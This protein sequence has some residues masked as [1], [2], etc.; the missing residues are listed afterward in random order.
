MTACAASRVLN[1][2]GA[3]RDLEM[4]KRRLS[5]REREKQAQREAMLEAAL[6][7]FSEKGYHSASMQEIAERAEFAVGTLYK[8]FENKADLYRNVVLEQIEEFDEAFDQAVNGLTDEVEQL[9]SYVRLKCEKYRDN[10]PFVRL[11]IAENGGS[12]LNVTAAS[13]GAE[14]Q[15]RYQDFLERLA[16][17]FETGMA[18]KRFK[19]I[20]PAFQM[21]VALDSAVN[22]FLLLWVEDPERHPFPE[23]PNVI[24]DIFFKG[25]INA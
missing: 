8:V 4:R 13:L 5:R 19:P 23:D 1:D 6:L 20:A 22:A 18:N 2:S 7:L 10:L 17:I 15:K 9:K 14:V 16:V 11:L 3:E 25:L 21:A 24:L 12:R